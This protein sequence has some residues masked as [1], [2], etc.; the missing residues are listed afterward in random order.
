MLE[1]L[2][3]IL[4]PSSKRLRVTSVP[5]MLQQFVSAVSLWQWLLCVPLDLMFAYPLISA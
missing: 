2:V 4:S 3:C 5:P 1:Q